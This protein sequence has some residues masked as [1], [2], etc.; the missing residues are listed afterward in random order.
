[1]RSR[2]D[3]FVKS[4]WATSLRGRFTPHSLFVDSRQWRESSCKTLVLMA[5]P[6]TIKNFPNQKNPFGIRRSLEQFLC[7]FL[8]IKNYMIF[9][10][11][12]GHRKIFRLEASKSAEKVTFLTGKEERKTPAD[13]PFGKGSRLSGRKGKIESGIGRLQI[14]PLDFLN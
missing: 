2:I 6:A 10:S 1:M 9:N 13:P 14:L 12:W 11:Y 7:R 4:P 3:G 8:W 5:F